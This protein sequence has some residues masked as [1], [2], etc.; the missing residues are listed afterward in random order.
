[1]HFDETEQE[2]TSVPIVPIID[3]LV[4]IVFFLLLS[5]SFYDLTQQSIPANHSVQ[6]SGAQTQPPLSPR[7]YIS[8]SG[9]SIVCTLVWSGTKAGQRVATVAAP[10]LVGPQ[11]ELSKKVGEL[12]NFI[13]TNFKSETSI[14]IGLAGDLPHQT[15]ISVLDGVAKNKMDV[16][17]VSDA[18]V[19]AYLEGRHKGMQQEN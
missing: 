17:L 4:A 10:T 16:V 3:M 7:L 13:K 19:L 6:V 14:Q 2:T 18:E 8:R 12:I 11:P 1:M 9:R 5:T 15:L